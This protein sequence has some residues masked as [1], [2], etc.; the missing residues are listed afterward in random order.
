MPLGTPPKPTLSQPTVSETLPERAPDVARVLLPG[1]AGVFAERAARLRELAPDSALGGYLALVA[2]IASAQAAIFD[3]R[4]PEPVSAD[5]LARSREHA[6]PA[7]DACGAPLP[8]A[9]REDLR[10]LVEAIARGPAA[11]RCAP[12]LASLRTADGGELD[13]IAARLLAGTTEDA[14]AAFVPFVGAALQVH[15]GRRAATVPVADVEGFDVD[16]VCPVCATRPVA[17]V[18]RTDGAVA[19]LRYLACALCGTQWNLARIRC[20]AC[21]DDRSLQYFGLDAD[22]HPAH[23]AW[24]AEACDECHSYLKVF[25]QAKDPG[26]DPVADD[27]ASLALDVLVDERGY[28]RSGPNLLF[29]PGSG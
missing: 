27:L 20:S 3:A 14:E 21:G 9:W 7:L 17:S 18:V 29:H 13:A 25:Q 19:N 1:G 4:L 6:M 12:L 16:T 8:A 26:V 5:A 23:D 24:R 11:E 15:F 2:E 22:G 28:V 10:D